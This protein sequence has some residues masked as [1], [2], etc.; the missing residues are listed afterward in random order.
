MDPPSHSRN[1]RSWI[2]S[3]E[4][5]VQVPVQRIQK[6][7]CAQAEEAAAATAAPRQSTRVIKIIKKEKQ[8]KET[9]QEVTTV[10]YADTL[11]AKIKTNSSQPAGRPAAQSYLSSMTLVTFPEGK[12]LLM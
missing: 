7:N 12:I 11:P 10:C 9:L 3:G 1:G 2:C 6:T 8:L 5:T 4:F